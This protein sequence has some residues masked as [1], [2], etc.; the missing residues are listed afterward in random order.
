MGREFELKYEA[1]P[2]KLALLQGR[3][4]DLSPITMETTYYDTPG[5]EMGRLYWTFRRRLENGRPVITLKTPAEGYGRNEWEVRCDDLMAAVDE[6]VAGGAPARLLAFALREGF[7]PVCGAR[8]T[9]LAGTLEIPGATV[10]LA[11]DQGV[12]LGGGKELPF[13]EMEVELKEGAEETAVRFAESLAGEVGL[14]PQPL[15]KIAR[16]RRLAGM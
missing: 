2:E 15:S 11:L 1:S 7:V 5:G 6:L 9:R 14:I 12:L 10:E 8:F 13:W 16:A 3:F 4:P